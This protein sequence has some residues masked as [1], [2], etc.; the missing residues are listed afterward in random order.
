[1]SE[2]GALGMV[3]GFFIDAFNSTPAHYIRPAYAQ[4]KI[5]EYNIAMKKRLNLPLNFE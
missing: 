4:A 5:D 1:M 2:L 3:V